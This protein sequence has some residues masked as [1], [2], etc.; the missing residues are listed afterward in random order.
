[1]AERGDTGRTSSRGA[2]LSWK[3]GNA[4]L[5]SPQDCVWHF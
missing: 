5:I 3:I 1:L 2:E 4:S